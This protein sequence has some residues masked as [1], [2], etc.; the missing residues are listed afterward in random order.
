MN[1]SL[2][3]KKEMVIVAPFKSAANRRCQTGHFNSSLIMGL[4]FARL[5]SLKWYPSV[6]GNSDRGF[7]SN[8]QSNQRNRN[9]KC[10]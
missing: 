2:I 6:V 1:G 5:L 3:L 9:A 8:L 7:L 4:F 10:Y